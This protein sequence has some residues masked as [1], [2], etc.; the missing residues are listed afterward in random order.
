MD[1]RWIATA[2]IIVAL[3]ALALI[4]FPPT[5]YAQPYQY[6]I[7]LPHNGEKV[8]LTGMASQNTM[9]LAYAMPDLNGQSRK[10]D[11]WSINTRMGTRS[12]LHYSDSKTEYNYSYFEA[13]WKTDI[14]CIRGSCVFPIGDTETTICHP[15]GTY[16]GYNVRTADTDGG[17]I[18]AG[19]KNDTGAGC[20]I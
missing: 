19:R 16:N 13:E 11:Y 10:I 17:R 9:H 18:I 4:F 6:E 7:T 20:P 14:I 15:N 1:K 8:W 5:Q 2:V 3:L 12:L